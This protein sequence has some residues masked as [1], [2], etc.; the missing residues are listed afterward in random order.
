[1]MN[2][3]IMSELIACLFTFLAGWFLSD[4]KP[5]VSGMLIA[6]GIIVGC[7]GELSK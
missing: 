2:T 5:V 4:A 6:C 3:A 1:M 7:F